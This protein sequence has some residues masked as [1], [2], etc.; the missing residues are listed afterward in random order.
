MKLTL[1]SCSIEFCESGKNK[2]ICTQ[3]CFFLCTWMQSSTTFLVCNLQ[4]HVNSAHTMDLLHTVFTLHIYIC[5]FPPSASSPC[6]PK[7]GESTQMCLR[8][9]CDY[10]RVGV[11]FKGPMYCILFYSVKQK[12]GRGTS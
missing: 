8:T 4:Y 10:L 5:S 11:V 3:V 1:T 9:T 7:Q 2:I 6:S 12:R